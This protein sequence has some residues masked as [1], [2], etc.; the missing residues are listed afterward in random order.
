MQKN[1]AQPGKDPPHKHT[2]AAL[3]H[4]NHIMHAV[5]ATHLA[6]AVV[7]VWR[8]GRANTL[9]VARPARQAQFLWRMGV[10]VC[11]DGGWVWFGVGV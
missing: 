11:V 8:F 1:K 10:G 2:C 6:C 7:A 9:G 5:A 4:D 3:L